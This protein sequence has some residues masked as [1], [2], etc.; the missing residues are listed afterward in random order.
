VRFEIIH[1]FEQPVEEVEAGMLDPEVNRQVAERMETILELEP[2]EVQEDGDIV[3]RRVRYLP[4]P[5]IRRVGPKKVEP[6]WMEWTEESQFDRSTH[7]MR[8]RNVPRVGKIARLMDNGGIVRLVP[9]GGGTRR[10]VEGELRIKVPI[11]GR[12]AERIIHKTGRSIVNEEAR[13][14]GELLRG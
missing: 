10:I 11:L 7:T 2:L 13:I 5:L 6:R 8:F 14:L 3:K 1:T 12:L 9:S 4:K